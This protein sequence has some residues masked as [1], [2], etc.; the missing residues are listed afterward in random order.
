MSKPNTIQDSDYGAILPTTK[1]KADDILNAAAKAGH[2][3]PRVYGFNTIPDHN[4]RRC[5]D[6]MHYGDTALR[7]WLE[8]Y[9]I[10]NAKRLGAEG[11]ISNRRVMDL[12]TDDAYRPPLFGWRNYT[13]S[14]PHTDHVHVQFNTAPLPTIRQRPNFWEASVWLRRAINANPAGSRARAAAQRA[15]NDIKEFVK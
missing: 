5:I 14:N 2:K 7:E 1:A 6:F 15:L 13:G 8:D 3:V 4:N 12:S 10:K 9:L 11:M